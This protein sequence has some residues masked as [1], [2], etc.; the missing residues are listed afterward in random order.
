MTTHVLTFRAEL[1]GS[2]SRVL[3]ACNMACINTADA[4]VALVVALSDYREEGRQLYPR[5]LVCDDLPQ[6]LRIV[7]GSSLLAIGCGKRN[8]STAAHALKRCAPLANGGWAVGINRLDDGFEYGVFRE[9]LAP[10][11]VDLRSTVTDLK[12]GDAKVVLISQ[13]APSTVEIV[14]SGHEPVEIHFSADALDARP[15]RETLDVLP[16]WLVEAIEDQHLRESAR[17]YWS[18][19][20]ADCLRAAHGALVAVVHVGADLPAELATD[21]VPVPDAPRV[22]DMLKQHDQARS[23]ESMSDLLAFGALFAG[24]L[25]SDGIAVLDTAGE[26]L[27]F[28]CFLR[29][30]AAEESIGG[31]RSRAFLTLTHLVD[32]GRLR[33]AFIRSSDG[34]SKIY[35][36]E[37]HDAG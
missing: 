23:A 14:S 31:A 35:E 18:T 19:L 27:A 6:V 34:Q 36:R 5:V 16:G 33:G 9:P 13:V 30:G 25:S 32:D 28:N 4:I 8:A 17:S 11:A 24:M 7:Q 1:H 10:T 37:G 22:I 21:G 29:I 20:L 12:V 15:T 3:D 26:L 2:V